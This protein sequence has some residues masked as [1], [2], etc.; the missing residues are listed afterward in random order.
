MT[1]AEQEQRL[2]DVKSTIANKEAALASLEQRQTQYHQQVDHAKEQLKSIEQETQQLKEQS[3]QTLERLSQDAALRL[4]LK[5]A[6]SAVA[7]PQS[8]PANLQSTPAMQSI[9]ND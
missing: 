1:L 7:Q 8:Q 9:E 5:T 3:E 4:G 6:V 2:H